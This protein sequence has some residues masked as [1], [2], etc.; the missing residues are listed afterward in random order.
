MALKIS[1]NQ[2]ATMMAIQAMDDAIKNLK[3]QRAALAA[4]LPV[5]PK[6]KPGEGKRFITNPYT[7]K[8]E[9]Y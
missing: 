3:Q 7:G 1:K 6:K 4:T 5:E 2:M 8:K 9:F